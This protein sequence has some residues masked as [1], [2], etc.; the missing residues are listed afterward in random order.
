MPTYEYQCP[1]H[2][3]F[4]EYHSIKLKLEHCPKCKENGKE[5]PV[6]RLISLGSRGVVELTG[7]DLVD[8]VKAD[9]QVLKKD[10]H[11]KEKI[12][13]NLLGEQKYQDLQVRLDKQKRDRR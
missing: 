1:E 8:K 9:A 12:Y 13:A 2:G 5:Q 10:A 11:A 7:Q 6:E 4:E 3:I